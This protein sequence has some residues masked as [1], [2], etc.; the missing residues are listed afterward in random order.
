MHK[1]IGVVYCVDPLVKCDLDQFWEW[2]KQQFWVHYKLFLERLFLLLISCGGSELPHAL[3]GPWADF[4]KGLACTLPLNLPLKST[5]NDKV[6]TRQIRQ[7]RLNNSLQ[8]WFIHA[9][10]VQRSSSA[11]GDKT[12]VHYPLWDKN[13]CLKHNNVQAMR[14]PWSVQTGTIRLQQGGRGGLS[15]HQISLQTP[16]QRTE[17]PAAAPDSS[18]HPV[19]TVHLGYLLFERCDKQWQ[20]CFVNT[21]AHDWFELHNCW[22]CPEK[23]EQSGTKMHFDTK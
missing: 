5:H 3:P 8:V 16:S 21:W 15:N 12:Q 20:P 4:V 14:W 13:H 18:Q 11:V 17:L 23:F 9:F 1:N 6:M 10:L 22:I 2:Q 19:N 7:K